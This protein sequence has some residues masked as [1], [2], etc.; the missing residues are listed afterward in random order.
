MGFTERERSNWLGNF[1]L[2]PKSLF[3]LHQDKRKR[4]KNVWRQAREG[5]KEQAWEPS[6]LVQLLAV[7]LETEAGF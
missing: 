3:T 6:S 4:I 7:I 5:H 1:S 2:S